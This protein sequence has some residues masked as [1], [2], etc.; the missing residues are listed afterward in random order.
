M[1]HLHASENT[2]G[3]TRRDYCTCNRVVA[4]GTL[5]PSIR[6]RHMCWG[7]CAMSIAAAS[8]TL[9]TT[10]STDTLTASSALPTA[11]SSPSESP[12]PCC[13]V[14]CMNLQESSYLHQP[15][16][17][18]WQHTEPRFSAAIAPGLVFASCCAAELADCRSLCRDRGMRV[19]EGS[20]GLVPGGLKTTRR[21]SDTAPVLASIL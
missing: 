13:S 16:F 10:L 3:H 2:L 7:G 14:G 8:A 12:M 20:S 6:V 15:F 17:F 5:R 4:R 19:D 18:Q 21:S 11:V 1:Q 9:E